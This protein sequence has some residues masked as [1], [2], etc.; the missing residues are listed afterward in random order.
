MND[1]NDFMLIRPGKWAKCG[2]CPFRHGQSTHVFLKYSQIAC[3][4][5]RHTTKN[6]HYLPF[7]W[8][9]VFKFISQPFINGFCFNMGHFEKQPMLELTYSNIFEYSNDQ[10]KWM[11]EENSNFW[12][13]LIH[14][15]P[16]F[17]P[18]KRARGARAAVNTPH[19]GGINA[20]RQRKTNG[21]RT[22]GPGTGGPVILR[23]GV[24][25]ND[26]WLN[27]ILWYLRTVVDPMRKGFA[28]WV[29]LVG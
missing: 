22:A 28:I 19:G 2:N 7:M 27:V 24:W 4:C 12:I 6:P 29:H 16:Y 26:L 18:T 15:I 20:L 3:S 10:V 23:F 8:T 14:C 17:R 13:L 11:N 5:G 21:A 25:K 1:S 9:Y